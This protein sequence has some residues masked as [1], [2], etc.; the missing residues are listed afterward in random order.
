M[1]FLRPV[2]HMTTWFEN[3][4]IKVDVEQKSMI[5]DILDETK[6]KTDI[7]KCQNITETDFELSNCNE[8]KK[9]ISQKGYR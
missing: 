3:K 7:L 9:Q 5:E 6:N 2:T 4:P 8:F 1:K